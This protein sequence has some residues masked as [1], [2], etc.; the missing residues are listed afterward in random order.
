MEP[1]IPFQLQIL[2]EPYEYITRVPGKEIRTMLIDAF[3][4]WMRVADDKVLIIKEVTKMLHNA[5]L[6]YVANSAF[7]SFDWFPLRP[8]PP[9]S[10]S[11]QWQRV[12]RVVS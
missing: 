2:L 6:L 5:S 9:A 12:A 11:C 10:C 7:A 8:L 3:N 1:L 4:L